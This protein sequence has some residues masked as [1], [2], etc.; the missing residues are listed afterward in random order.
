MA[1][2]FAGGGIKELQEADMI[3]VTPVAGMGTVDILGIY[4]TLETLS[5]Q[6][7][8]LLLVIVSIIYYRVKNKHAGS[9]MAG[10]QG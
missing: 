6:I 3:G 4:P 9:G 2:A 8:M 5:P 10:E 7:V 1:I